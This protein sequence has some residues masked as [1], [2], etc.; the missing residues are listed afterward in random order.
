MTDQTETESAL[1]AM[2]RAAITARERASR[3]GSQLVLWRDGSVVLVDPRT[4]GAEQGGADQPA[5][6]VESEVK[7]KEEAAQESE[8]RP[9]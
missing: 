6:A 3:F 8:G 4:S 7:G 1:A 5:T 9:Q 2:N